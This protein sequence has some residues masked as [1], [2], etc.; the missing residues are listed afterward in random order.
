MGTPGVGATMSLGALPLASVAGGKALWYLTRATG[1][2]ALV[3]LTAS[4]VLGVAAAV[5]W[6]TERW[7]RFLSQSLHRNV[8]LFCVVFVGIHVVTTVSDG[9]VPIGFTSAFLPFLTPYRPIWIGLGALS[10]D[11]LLAVMLTSALRRR[12]GYSSWRFVHWLAYLSWPIAVF[13]SLG[14][15]SDSPLPLVLFLDAVCTAAVVAAVACRLATGRTFPLGRRAV[16]AVGTAVVVLAVVVFASLGPLRPGWSHRAGTSAALLAQLAKR[17]APAGGTT[18]SAGSN[19]AGAGWPSAPFTDSLAG[20]VATKGP[21][22]QGNVQATFTLHLLDASSTSLDVVL[23]GTAAQG[24]GIAMSSGTV[25]FGGYRGVV[26][27]LSG[28][29]VGAS[30]ST[31]TPQSL[32]LSLSIDRSSNAVTGQVSGAVAGGGTN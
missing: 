4:V 32:M 21:D 20:T 9:Y 15:G 5:G 24:G 23:N 6:A 19:T 11:L 30:V 14:S 16:A 2:V 17:Y 13:H 22:V 7:P 31:P 1:L 12:I 26:T 3:L 29:T 8:S 27:T 18:P 25:T 28:N 10:F